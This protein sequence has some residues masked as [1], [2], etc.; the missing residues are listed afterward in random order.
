MEPLCYLMMLGNFTVSYAFYLFMRMEHDLELGSI[1]HLLTE[2]MTRRKAIRAG[3]DLV[4]HQ[5]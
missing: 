3:I 4:K 5:A 1:H 2:R